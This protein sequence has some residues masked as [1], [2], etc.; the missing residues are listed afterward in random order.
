MR[1]HK[2]KFVNMLAELPA[3]GSVAGAPPPC[4]LAQ[5]AQGENAGRLLIL[6][7]V[8]ALPQTG[9]RHL[10]DTQC[11]LVADQVPRLPRTPHHSGASLLPALFVFLPSGEMTCGICA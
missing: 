2:Q 7:V 6:K 8:V 10:A 9:I 11:L 4:G 3:S 5:L 1:K